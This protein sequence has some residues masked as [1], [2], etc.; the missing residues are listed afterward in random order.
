MAI[1]LSH[2]KPGCAHH[3]RQRVL[4]AAAGHRVQAKSLPARPLRTRWI[5]LVGMAEHA[6]AESAPRPP[7]SAG[8]SAP[9]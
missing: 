6:H 7:A 9:S 5:G 1:V 2:E 4:L 3:A 8:E